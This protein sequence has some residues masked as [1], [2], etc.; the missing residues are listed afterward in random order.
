MMLSLSMLTACGGSGGSDTSPG[1]P[2]P[3]AGGSNEDPEEDDPKEESS[4]LDTLPSVIA[5]EVNE[6]QL[7]ALTIPEYKDTN[8]YTFT[9]VDGDNVE[10]SS[11]DG[12]VVFKVEADFE[13][14]P[15][16]NFIMTV[17]NASEQTKDIDVTINIIDIPEDLNSLPSVIT[18]SV[19]ENSR[20]ALAIPEY[21]DTNS[22]V[23]SGSDGDKV[24]LWAE[25]SEVIFNNAPDFES[26]AEYNFII[27][28][29]NEMEQTKEI[30][31][32]I[33]VKDIT[34]D[35]IFELVEGTL[36]AVYITF[37]ASEYEEKYDTYSFTLQ[38]GDEAPEEYVYV[39]DSSTQSVT[40]KGYKGA[41][42]E[43]QQFTIKPMADG[44]LPGIVFS[45]NFGYQEI[46]V[47]QWGDNSWQT[48]NELFSYVC[49]YDE[50]EITDHLSFADGANSPN[51][52]RVNNMNKA[53]SSCDFT[54]DQSYWDVS[55]VEEMSGLFYAGKGSV[56][57]SQWDVSSV[58]NMES[59]FDNAREFSGDLSKWDVSS[60]INMEGMFLISRQFNSDISQWVTSAVE[61][62]DYMF[63]EN[64]KFDQDISG[65]DVTKVTSCVDFKTNAVLSEE[66][67]PNI[68][69]CSAP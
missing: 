56:D 13:T 40:L 25:R 50:D 43:S 36:G 1:E 18:E 52:S 42:E 5:E 23:F 16:Y 6:N 20:F 22:Y 64:D 24:K 12:T 10:L 17:T 15:V 8:T 38:K 39:G 31:V 41:L 4:D 28:V 69:H 26:K 11:E 67:T 33:K 51:L 55:A 65:W 57:I 59:L 58:T 54:E 47:I 35:F 45:G 68:E 27:T 34:N 62:M 66:H 48:L 30:D 7:L 32:T 61:S 9:G 44:G 21:K 2:T 63:Y 60:V 3:S 37:N 46:K 49:N 53:L 29:T 19:N 14:Q